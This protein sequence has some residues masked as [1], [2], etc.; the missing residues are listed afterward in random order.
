MKLYIAG[1]DDI[2]DTLGKVKTALNEQ[3]MK[4]MRKQG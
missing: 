4:K 3:I 2:S 1:Y